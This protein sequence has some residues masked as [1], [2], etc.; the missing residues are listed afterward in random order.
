MAASAILGPLVL[1]VIEFRVSENAEGQLI[2]GE[3]VSLFVAAPLAVLAGAFWL[4]GHRLAPV[5]AIGPA[6]YALYLYVQLIVG[7]DYHRYPGNNERF[8]PLFLAVVIL[9]WALA[10]RAWSAVGVAQLPAP[11]AGL[12]RLLAGILIILSGIF[13][14]AWTASIADVLVGESVAQAYEEDPTLFWLVRLMDLGFVIPAAL[15]TGVGL[16]RRAPWATR[17]AYA[18]TAFLT[19]EVGAVAGMSTAMTVR[20]DP[21]ADPVLLVVTV[22]STLALVLLDARLLRQAQT[23]PASGR[24]VGPRA[25]DGSSLGEAQRP[26][27][28]R[29]GDAPR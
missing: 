21:A 26:G 8:F 25:G 28:G 15:I 19:L 5:L 1:G 9:G 12:R 14:L 27:R 11:A 3:I 7:P 29:Y 22:I 10:L 23:V 17:P 4:R 16:L 24:D 13:A 6:L 2:G 18:V 20:D